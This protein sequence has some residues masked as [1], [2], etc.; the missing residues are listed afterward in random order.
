MDLDSEQESTQTDDVKAL[1]GGECSF[2]M[3]AL[4]LALGE[5]LETPFRVMDEFDVFLDPVA[6]KIALDTLVEIVRNKKWAK[7]LGYARL[8]RDV[9]STA[10]WL[11]TTHVALDADLLF[12]WMDTRLGHHPSS[13]AQTRTKRE[14]FHDIVNDVRE[15]I[16]A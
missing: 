16:R 15:S 2:T 3:L 1:S 12:G 14:L 7:G 10:D 8:V 9:R 11:S 13:Q 4:L 6:R 5:R